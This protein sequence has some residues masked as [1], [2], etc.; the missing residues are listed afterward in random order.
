[1]NTKILGFLF[2]AVRD[3][4][5]NSRS[6]P[7]VQAEKLLFFRN[8]KRDLKMSPKSKRRMSFGILVM[9]A[10][11]ETFVK[12][13]ASLKSSLNIITSTIKMFQKG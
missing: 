5:F 9:R 4:F 2:A 13:S 1:V 8:R 10:T 6:V 12:N 7:M 11:K 3:R